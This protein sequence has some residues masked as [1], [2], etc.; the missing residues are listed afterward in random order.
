MICLQKTSSVTLCLVSFC[1]GIGLETCKALS[2]AG[3]RV[4]LC[5]R[6]VAA[7]EKAIAEEIKTFGEGGYIGD[8]SNIIVKELDLN[9]LTSIKRFALDFLANE[10]SLDFL[11]LNAG[12][13]ALPKLERTVDGFEKQ[14]GVNHMGHA[15]LVSF[16]EDML[17]KQDHP[18]RVIC[19]SSAAHVMGA[20]DV[21]DLHF[22]KG[23]KYT[24][25]GAYGQSKLAN[26]LF[27]RALGKRLEGTKST[28]L[29]L[30]PGEF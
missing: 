2:F 18:S 3:A 4:I 26:L 22:S 20:V 23:R 12:I 5:S 16:L 17:R 14:I 15:Y 30:H 29:S 21:K 10:K 1:S 11:V 28:A 27:A 19:V 6:S 9:S 24:D 8:T 7:A 13:M 25:W